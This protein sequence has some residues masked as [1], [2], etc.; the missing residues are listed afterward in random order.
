MLIVRIPETAQ[1]WEKY[2]QL[3]YT[4]LRE[5]WG[6]LKGS[7]VLKDEDQSDHVMVIDDETHEIVGVA[8]LQINTPTQGQVRCVAVAPHAQ[9]KGVGKL[10]MN[11]LE[12]LAQQKD[13]KEIILD[14]RENAVKFYLSIGY[15]I[16]E[17]SYLLF[18]VIQHWKMRKEINAAS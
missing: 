15:E 13:I 8:R 7:E 1:E 17:E 5:P 12:E 10:L 4:V 18:G 6:Q 16:F 9:G 11:Y 2:Y 14:A 3:R